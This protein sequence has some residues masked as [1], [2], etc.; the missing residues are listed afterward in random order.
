MQSRQRVLA[1]GVSSTTE[2]LSCLRLVRP[3]KL[4]I[5]QDGG[6]PEKVRFDCID[7]AGTRPRRRRLE[8]SR[9]DVR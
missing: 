5:G 8:E 9:L 3:A 4:S 2:A 6:H 7:R 1:L